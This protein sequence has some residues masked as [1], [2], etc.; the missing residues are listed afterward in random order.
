MNS[1]NAKPHTFSP[2]PSQTHFVTTAARLANAMR[3]IT[4][5]REQA[6]KSPGAEAKIRYM[7][8]FAGIGEKYARNIWMDVYHPEF[9][10]RIAVD[11]RI[12]KASERL[13]CRFPTYAAEERFYLDA[14]KQ[15]GLDG[16]ELDRLLYNYLDYFLVRLK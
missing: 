5:A 15:A 10:N 11:Q 1:Y 3:G 7:L 8:Q 12:K 16:W 9:R 13:G 6:M 4:A 2:T 14:A